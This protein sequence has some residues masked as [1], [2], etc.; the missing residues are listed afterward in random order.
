MDPNN[1]LHLMVGE[2]RSDVKTLLAHAKAHDTRITA[3]EHKQWYISGGM[4]ALAVFIVP[5][6]KMVLGLA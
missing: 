2:I 4:A 3:V 5:K 6:L 1:E